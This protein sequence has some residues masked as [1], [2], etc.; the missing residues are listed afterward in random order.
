M[1]VRVESAS[2]CSGKEERKWGGE[3]RGQ[4]E[5]E[6]QVGCLG[7]RSGTWQQ[8]CLRVGTWAAGDWLLPVNP[9]ALMDVVPVSCTT[10]SIR[11][12]NL[13]MNEYMLWELNRC[14]LFVLNSVSS[15]RTP[16]LRASPLTP[17]WLIRAGA[18]S[19]VPQDS[20]L[21]GK[22]PVALTSV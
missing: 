19:K 18:P 5:E 15:P 8:V 13:N 3:R 14:L 1:G 21:V 22:D 9:L 12:H 11:R 2:I 16:E 10:W 4:E 7:G 17:C 6:G 20:Q